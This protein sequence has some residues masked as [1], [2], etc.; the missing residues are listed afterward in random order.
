MELEAIIVKLLDFFKHI[1]RDLLIYALSG[2][3]VLSNFFLID[4]FYNSEKFG[5]LFSKI[6]YNE[7]IFIAISYI[8]GHITMGIMYVLFEMVINFDKIIVHCFDINI[9]KSIELKLFKENEKIYE[10]FIERENALYFMRWTLSGAF[11]VSVITNYCFESFGGIHIS[12][13]VYVACGSISL[14]LLILHYKTAHTY[15]E[16]LKHL[17]KQYNICD[18]SDNPHPNHFELKCKSND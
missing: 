7:L 8:L 10:Y 12:L 18:D 1:A 15:S 17:K 16:T 11:L 2:I 6:E 4:Y 5:I 9:S 13:P 14:I 3:V